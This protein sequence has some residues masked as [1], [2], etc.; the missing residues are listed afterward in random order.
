VLL[1][2]VVMFL[3]GLL[4]R[5]L[6]KFELGLYPVEKLTLLCLLRGQLWQKRTLL[7]QVLP[8]QLLLLERHLDVL[9]GVG[10]NLNRCNYWRRSADLARDLLLFLVSIVDVQLLNLA[11]FLVW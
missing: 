8:L 11:G 7:L 6:C 2:L 9:V 4:F 3:D 10:A 5:L 1:S